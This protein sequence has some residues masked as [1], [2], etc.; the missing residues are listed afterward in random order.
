MP[1]A[2]HQAGWRHNNSWP[3]GRGA[4]GST[5]GGSHTHKFFPPAALNLNVPTPGKKGGDPNLGQWGLGPKE[6]IEAL[7]ALEQ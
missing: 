2:A 6:T 3:D 7:S 1:L 4:E 5:G